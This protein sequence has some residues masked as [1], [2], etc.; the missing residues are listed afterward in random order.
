MKGYGSLKPSVFLYL[1]LIDS[2]YGG[3]QIEI[4]FTVVLSVCYDGHG[5]YEMVFIKEEGIRM[6]RIRRICTDL[7]FLIQ[8]IVLKDFLLHKTYIEKI[9]L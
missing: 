6:P 7:G 8:I 2:N 1:A 3:S 5:V 9:K 4:S